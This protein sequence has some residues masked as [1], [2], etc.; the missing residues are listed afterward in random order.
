M[1][2]I[3]VQDPAK[4]ESSLTQLKA[5]D[6]GR[7]IIEHYAGG[8]E[9]FG[10]WLALADRRMTRAVGVGFSDISDW[11][12]RDAYDEGYTPSEA[13]REALASDDTYAAM[14]GGE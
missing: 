8:D 3:D 14:F 7:H 4:V 1:T 6:R 13:A 9:R 5:T 11:R 2:W 10:L 12:W